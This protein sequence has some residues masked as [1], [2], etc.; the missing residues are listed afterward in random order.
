MPPPYHYPGRRDPEQ[1]AEDK[2]RTR[3]S[4]RD[5][6]E[7]AARAERAAFLAHIRGTPGGL[8]VRNMMPSWDTYK[9]SPEMSGNTAMTD[10]ISRYNAKNP[11]RA[12]KP[13]VYTP[14]ARQ[15]A[16]AVAPAAPQSRVMQN[17]PAVGVQ[18][19]APLAPQSETAAEM[20]KRTSGGME[21][22]LN[23]QG[24]V[25]D[26][27]KKN[28][29]PDQ[30][31]ERAS[32]V[33]QSAS[34]AQQP[35]PLD[36]LQ[37]A[38]KRQAELDKVFSTVQRDDRPGARY[39]W[40]DDGRG[41]KLMSAPDPNDPFRGGLQDA[42]NAQS[43]ARV[44]AAVNGTKVDPRTQ[45][46]AAARATAAAATAPRAVAFAPAPTA[47]TPQ[48]LSA[49]GAPS[50]AFNGLVTTQG[51]TAF[52]RPAGSPA[53]AGAGIYDN[54]K[55]TKSLTPRTDQVMATSAGL[56]K[57]MPGMGAMNTALA[58]VTGNASM[59]AGANTADPD[60]IASQ[61]KA[62]TNATAPQPITSA[63]RTEGAGAAGDLTF[64]GLDP[65]L[66]EDEKAKKRGELLAAKYKPQL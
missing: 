35:G 56:D 64:A 49:S 36:T 46:D 28:L 53:M 47:L 23:A 37:S 24:A 11:Q 10:Y 31:N 51:T 33:Q 1:E 5:A 30:M 55:N 19:G 6:M 42:I 57:L 2:R 20:E 9:N 15:A 34:G 61:A 48:Q 27:A 52:A 17:A 12:F 16:P 60:S 41:Q 8:S 63:V 43:E 32:A 45:T 38:S 59:L 21:D 54:G 65:N 39:G 44:N 25:Q 14:Q 22:A 3:T 50:D 58:K 26:I 66:S 18:A 62:A 7:G 4:N 40:V 29:T 13:E